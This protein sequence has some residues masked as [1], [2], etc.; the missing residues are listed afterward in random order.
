MVPQKQLDLTPV[1]ETQGLLAALEQLKKELAKTN[2]IPIHLDADKD[3][4]KLLGR[5]AEN[6]ILSIVAETAANALAHAEAGNLYLRLHQHGTDVIT[7]VE[8]DGVGFDVAKL[9]AS[10]AEAWLNFEERAAQVNV[11]RPKTSG[12]GEA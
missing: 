9:K 6:T 11:A 8:D 1:L 12:S 5:P 4:E 10:R 3:V 2:P 7:E